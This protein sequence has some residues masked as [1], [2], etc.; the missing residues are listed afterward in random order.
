MGAHKS[1]WWIA[2]PRSSNM[3]NWDILI[4]VAL[5]YTSFIT[6]YEVAFSMDAGYADPL[7]VLNRIIDLTFLID[8]SVKHAVIESIPFR[9]RVPH[10]PASDLLRFVSP[11]AAPRLPQ[12]VINFNLMC[13]RSGGPPSSLFR[14]I[15]LLTIPRCFAAL[16]LVSSFY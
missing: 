7:F 6:P 9:G 8:V 11:A 3:R 16:P 4:V 15:P 13:G 14:S 2:D 1:S 5:I 10:G 12:I